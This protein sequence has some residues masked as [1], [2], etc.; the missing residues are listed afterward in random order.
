MAYTAALKV[1]GL[2]A[3]WVRVPPR[4]PLPPAASNGTGLAAEAR[5][6][7][8]GCAHA[9]THSIPGSSPSPAGPFCGKII[10]I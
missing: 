3:M 7:G 5:K 1:A 6:T 4:A 10:H 2:R 9:G 8:A